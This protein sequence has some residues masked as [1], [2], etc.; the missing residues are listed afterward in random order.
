MTEYQKKEARSEKMTVIIVKPHEKARIAEIGTEIFTM[1]SSGLSSSAI[2]QE[3]IF[4]GFL[5][6]RYRN[7]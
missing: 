3:K 1:L 6:N 2:V 5:K 4:Q 7:I